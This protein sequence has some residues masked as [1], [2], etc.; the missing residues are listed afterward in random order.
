M[1]WP[2]VA[3]DKGGSQCLLSSF[4]C[5]AARRAWTWNLVTCEAPMWRYTDTHA[6]A[7]TEITVYVLVYARNCQ[8]NR[9]LAFAF[10]DNDYNHFFSKNFQE[11]LRYE[12]RANF[13]IA[14][15]GA[16]LRMCGVCA[17]V[18]PVAAIKLIDCQDLPRPFGWA[19][20][21]AKADQGGLTDWFMRVSCENFHSYSYK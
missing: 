10:A 20:I 7:H 15:A 4:F 9:W 1:C 16:P 12:V 19:V 13:Q 17:S 14:L 21:A 6:L 8:Y 5:E 3:L 18:I 11:F 2:V